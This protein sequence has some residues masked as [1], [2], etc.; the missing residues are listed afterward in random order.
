MKIYLFFMWNEDKK[1]TIKYPK[2]EGINESIF[3]PIKKH[4][5]VF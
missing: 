2:S 5:P 3:R 1:L 4:T